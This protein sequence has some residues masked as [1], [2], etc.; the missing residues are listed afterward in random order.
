MNTEIVVSVVVPVRRAE[1][2]IRATLNSLLAQ[3]CIE[4]WEV[5]LVLSRND[6]TAGLLNRDLPPPVR[7]LEPPGPGGVPQLRRDGVRQARGEFIV[8]TEDHCLYP[9]GW[10]QG[11]LD[12]MQ[13]RGVEAAGGP[14]LNASSSLTGLALYLTRYSAFLPGIEGHATEL[15]GN[16]SCYRREALENDES[17][18]RDGFW[19]AEFNQHLVR[20][21]GRMWMSRDSAVQQKQHRGLLEFAMLRF[22]HGRCYGARRIRSASRSERRKRLL[23]APLIPAVLFA[24]IMRAVWTKRFPKLRFAAAAPLILVYVTCW[25]AGEITGYLAG[26]GNSCHSTD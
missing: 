24:R 19:E 5:I 8:I 2:T 21:G 16:N 9:E 7:L 17:W 4:P 25:A 10:L 26:A 3:R 18:M 14:V 6:P 13:T 23:T 22:R 15:P 12:C 20:C 11:L 1:R